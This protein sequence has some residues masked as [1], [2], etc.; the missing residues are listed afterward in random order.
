MLTRA[1]PR[2]NYNLDN[3]AGDA[4]QL[5]HPDEVAF[6]GAEVEQ[7]DRAVTELQNAFEEEDGSFSQGHQDSQSSQSSSGSTGYDDST[8]DGISSEDEDGTEDGTEIRLPENM[9]SG[10]DEAEDFEFGSSQESRS[11]DS[12]DDSVSVPQVRD[13]LFLPSSSQECKY[14][15]S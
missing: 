9:C 12:T 8:E 4:S 13:P 2:F 7:D 15:A 10:L 6:H 3:L 14:S 11:L 5:A 1:T